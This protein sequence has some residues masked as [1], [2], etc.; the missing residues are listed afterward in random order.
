MK[1]E[2]NSCKVSMNEFYFSKVEDLQITP[3]LKK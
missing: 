2:E 3:F 1:Y